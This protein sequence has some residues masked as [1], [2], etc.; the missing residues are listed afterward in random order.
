MK[1]L[2]EHTR[3]N[4]ANMFL[5]AAD[6]LGWQ[7]QFVTEGD[8]VIAELTKNA[9]K[10][11]LL[12]N[13]AR[14]SVNNS[15]STAIST[16][17]FLTH[18][19]L[20]NKTPYIAA[21]QSHAIEELTDEVLLQLLDQHKRLVVKPLAENNGVGITTDLSSLEDLK[22]AINKVKG[23]GEKN[24]LIENHIETTKEYRI[25]VWKGKVIDVIERLPAYVTGDGT[26]TIQ[27]LID[28]KN[29]IR[30]VHFPKEVIV[31]D[32]DLQSNLRQAD[33]TLESVPATDTHVKLRK[34][35]NMMQGGETK[36]IAFET[37]HPDYFELFRVIYEATWLNYYGADLITTSV[38]NAAEQGK[39]IVN[40]LNASPGF[41]AAYF[42]DIA[43]NTPLLGCKRILEQMESNPV[44]LF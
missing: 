1:I 36:R 19:V 41:P 8:T 4:D 35:C 21:T 27:Q 2:T 28:A 9:L 31:V 26:S 13:G 23:L 29:K 7:I 10:Y 34:M 6:Q 15:V 42:A 37:V 33:L 38:E 30:V 5:T 3:F 43:D 22:K 12:C 16:N 44:Q 25:I 39:T 11:R 18:E 14:I 32:E 20:K 40:E 17:K 24:V